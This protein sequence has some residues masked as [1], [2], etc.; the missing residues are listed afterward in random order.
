MPL[1]VFS[2]NAHD[3]LM[4]LSAMTTVIKDNNQKLTL[5]NRLIRRN[6]PNSV[7]P[8]PISAKLHINLHVQF[9]QFNKIRLCESNL[10]FAIWQHPTPILTF[11][12]KR[13][14]D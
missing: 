2:P 3:V 7:Q 6:N 11:T 1:N 9:E 14:S 12:R 5:V 4:L 10:P 8:K 13:A